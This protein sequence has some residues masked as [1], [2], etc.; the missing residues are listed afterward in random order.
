MRVAA[1]IE[2]DPIIRKS[3]F[4]QLVDQFSFYIALKIVEFN[5]TEFFL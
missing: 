3:N 1:G 4:V 5:L 2:D